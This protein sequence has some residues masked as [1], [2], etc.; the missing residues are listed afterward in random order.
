MPLTFDLDL[1]WVK[2]GQSGLDPWI[3]GPSLR[4]QQ[5]VPTKE[6]SSPRFPSSLTPKP[7]WLGTFI[8]SNENH[9]RHC[10]SYLLP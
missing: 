9:L 8:S 6:S 5:V 7:V 4:E 2:E 3:V 10:V 1:I